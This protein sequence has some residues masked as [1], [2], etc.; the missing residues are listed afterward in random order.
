MK[1]SNK[2]LF[3]ASKDIPLHFH[4]IKKTFNEFNCDIFIEYIKLYEGYGIVRSFYKSNSNI[5][6]LKLDGDEYFNK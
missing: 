6:P 5:I 4:F 1:K 2:N 3:K